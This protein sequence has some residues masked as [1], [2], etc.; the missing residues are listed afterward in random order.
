MSRIV[1]YFSDKLKT[2]KEY[3]VTLT[4]AVYD[5]DGNRLDNTLDGIKGK[6]P[7]FIN[8]DFNANTLG[9]LDAYVGNPTEFIKW[10]CANG[11][12]G[13][14]VSYRGI[15]NVGSMASYMGMFTGASY[16]S[17]IVWGYGQSPTSVTCDGGVW[18]VVPL[19]QRYSATEHIVGVWTDGKPVCERT[20]TLTLNKY[21]TNNKIVIWNTLFQYG[22]V[23]LISVCG[24]LSYTVGGSIETYG[25]GDSLPSNDGTVSATSFITK[26]PGGSL[27]CYFDTQNTNITAVTCTITY[28]YTRT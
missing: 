7:N 10:L 23:E 9:V 8:M 21:T 6:I 22:V 15:L 20:V 17:F 2:L 3:P 24:T 11:Y 19:S 27:T 4:K 25:F 28:R 16:A 18:S 1:Q 14:N 26:S 13:A 5:E 12:F